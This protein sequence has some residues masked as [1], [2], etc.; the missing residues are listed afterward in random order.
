MQIWHLTTTKHGGATV[1]FAADLDRHQKAVNVVRF[2]PSREILASGDDGW[3]S[4]LF[5]Y[6][7]HSFRCV[8]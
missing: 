1:N 6:L 2:S 4:L 8:R 3:P 5:N 7:L